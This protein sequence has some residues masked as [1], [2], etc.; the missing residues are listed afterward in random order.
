MASRIGLSKKTRHVAVHYLWVQERVE[1][2]DLVLEKVAGEK[3]PADMGTKYLPQE[4][5]RKHLDI[6]PNEI[7]GGEDVVPK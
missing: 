2:G 5:M 6:L 7:S 4:T 3:N 1:A